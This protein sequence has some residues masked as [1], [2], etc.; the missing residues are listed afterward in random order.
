MNIIE[1]MKYMEKR[2]YARMCDITFYNDTFK[3]FENINLFGNWEKM[4]AYKVQHF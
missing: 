2:I 1:S 3:F 4:F